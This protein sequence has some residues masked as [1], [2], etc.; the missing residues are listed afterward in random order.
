MEIPKEKILELIRERVGGEK[1]QQADQELPN[2]VD[3]EQHGDLLSKYGVNPQDLLGGGLGDILKNVFG[4]RPVPRSSQPAPSPGSNPLEDIPGD[5]L[6]GGASQGRVVVKQVSPD[7]MG[8]IL[9]DIF[10]GSPQHQPS[11]DTVARGR[12]TLDD[13]LGGGTKTGKAADDLLNSVENAVR[14]RL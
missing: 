10:C 8:E 14:H 6:G 2:Q 4:E 1:A 7:Q 3:P 12:K 11:E 13:M 5:I 9:K